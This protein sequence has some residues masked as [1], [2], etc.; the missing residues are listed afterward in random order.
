MK[1][2]KPFKVYEGKLA[3]EDEL[4]LFTLSVVRFSSFLDDVQQGL[5][6]IVPS[7]IKLVHETASRNEALKMSN[8]VEF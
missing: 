1:D 3:D 4:F 8:D 5:I 2:P 6:E 7:S